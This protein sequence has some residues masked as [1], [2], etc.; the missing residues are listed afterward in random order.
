M[1][2]HVNH[3]PMFFRCASS[4]STDRV[5]LPGN[6]P[7]KALWTEATNFYEGFVNVK[8]SRRHLEVHG[9]LEF[10]FRLYVTLA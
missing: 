9:T 4:T 5:I 2:H 1:C 7:S 3:V 8:P 6:G 10:K